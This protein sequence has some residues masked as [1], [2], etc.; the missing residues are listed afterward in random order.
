[1]C[2]KVKKVWNCGHSDTEDP[3]PCPQANNRNRACPAYGFAWAYRDPV[4]EKPEGKCGECHAAAIEEAGRE[5]NRQF[6]ERSQAYPRL[7]D[8]STHDDRRR[9]LEGRPRFDRTLSGPAITV[10][11]DWTPEFNRLPSNANEFEQ[12]LRGRYNPLQRLPDSHVP[13]ELSGRLLWNGQRPVPKTPT[14][15]V[16]RQVQGMDYFQPQNHA[17]R[18]QQ[19]S[20]HQM[21]PSTARGCRPVAT[22]ASFAPRPRAHKQADSFIRRSRSS[23]GSK[24]AQAAAGAQQRRQ[25][26]QRQDVDTAIEETDSLLCERFHDLDLGAPPQLS[27]SSNGNYNNSRRPSC[28]STHKNS[29]WIP[30]VSSPLPPKQV[31]D[32]AMPSNGVSP[33]TSLD[34]CITRSLP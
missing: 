14:T 32:V 33:C 24:E 6:V 19:P 31:M 15:P 23:Y 3:R 21:R 10:P 11:K 29:G 12:L 22:P 34:N 17:F 30:A 5:A 26:Q 7:R 18:S 13:A 2:Q 28:T 9:L 4:L 16:R 27:P 25:Q 8:M 1:M 20:T